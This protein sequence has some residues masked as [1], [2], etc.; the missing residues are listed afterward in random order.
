[1][2]DKIRCRL[3]NIDSAY[4]TY[5]DDYGHIGQGYSDWW[6]VTKEELRLLEK[7][8]NRHRASITL[9]YEHIEDGIP[10]TLEAILASQKEYLKKEKE[11]RAARAKKRELAKLKREQKDREFLKKKYEE[12]KK[13][14]EGED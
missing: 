6:E 7:Y 3:F 9:V 5:G 8:V 4:D 10:V 13:E 11:R 14:F 12:L 1:M 2:T